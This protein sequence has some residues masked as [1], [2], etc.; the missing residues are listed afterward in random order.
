MTVRPFLLLTSAVLSLA[1]APALEPDPPTKCGPCDE[2][3]RPLDPFRVYGNTYYVGTAGLTAVLVTSD[4]GHI[5]LDA[6]LPQ[7]APLIDA[8]IRK[9][10]FRTEDIRLI[11]NSHAHFDHAGG[12]AALQRVSGATVAASEAGARALRQG[13]PGPDDPQPNSDRYGP[14]ENVKVIADGEAVRVGPLAVTAHFTPGHTPGA[15]SWTWRSCEGS[16]C[17]NVVYVDS[18][19]AVSEDGFR[20]T[21]SPSLVET[22]R[23]SIAVVEQL[24]CDVLLAPHP[25]AIALEA[26]LAAMKKDKRVNPFIDAG[27][28]QAFAATQRKALEARLATEKP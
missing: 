9:L 16:R 26:K 23:R 6:G 14:V 24:P 10:G 25:F 15:A 19:S 18:L 4:A 12:I 3:N 11:V 28:C 1:Q 22:F 17:L 7:S 13:A 5:L 20:F 27:A 8:S 21:A 2:W